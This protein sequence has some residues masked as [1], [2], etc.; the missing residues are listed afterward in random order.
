MKK[1]IYVI[2]TLVLLLCILVPVSAT[3]SIIEA[4]AVETEAVIETGAGTTLDSE[5]V[6]EI[7][8]A[9][10]GDRGAAIIRLAERLGI[11]LDEAEDI[12]N[13]VLEVGDE[14]L[15]D[16]KYWIAFRTDVQEDMQYWATA[17]VL[18]FA[19]L[20]IAG[21]IFVLAGKTNPTVRKV[22]YILNDV[23]NTFKTG[24]EEQSQTIGKMREEQAAALEEIRN[25]AKAAAEKEAKFEEIVKQKDA[26]IVTLVEHIE[27]LEEANER[28][29]KNMLCAEMY[30]LQAL[31][32]TLSRTNLPLADKAVIDLWFARAEESL[33]SDM[34]PEDIDKI[35]A[36][37]AVLPGGQNEEE[38]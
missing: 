27:A 14:E 20:V 4:D 7:V 29:R 10:E 16:N 24:A 11:S 37:S 38:V 22:A 31:K 30:N 17:I 19:A 34:D 2:T 32:L 18:I 23:V 8:G 13:A 25:A 28:E 1:I 5:A 12:I 3:E 21:G 35:A 6:S 26:E 33:K 36:M 15:G 9:L